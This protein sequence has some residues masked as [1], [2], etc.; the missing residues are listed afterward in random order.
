MPAN[1]PIRHDLNPGKLVLWSGSIMIIKLK[2]LNDISS[3]VP[4]MHL[5]ID[6]SGSL[7]VPPF[8]AVL[9]E[10]PL[11]GNSMDNSA[12]SVIIAVDEN[13]LYPS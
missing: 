7:I 11:L 5:Q 3:P 12:G 6:I 10:F 9:F 8:S 4:A 1:L 13:R 2:L